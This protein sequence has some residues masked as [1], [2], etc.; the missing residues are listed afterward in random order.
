MEKQLNLSKRG[1][2]AYAFL[3]DASRP[4]KPSG[5]ERQRVVNAN[6]TLALELHKAVI[7][8][9]RNRNATRILEIGCGDGN[10]LN[11]LAKTNRFRDSYLFGIDQSQ[12]A[13]KEAKTKSKIA[14]LAGRVKFAVGRNDKIPYHGKF[15]LVF[16]VLSFHEWKNGYTSIPYILGRISE[17]GAFIIY[18]TMPIDTKGF[19]KYRKYGSR[20]F[21]KRTQETAKIVFHRNG[22]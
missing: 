7:E 22:G 4:R 2:K 14:G 9:L 19:L 3:T 12:K 15:D 10:M 5:K 21:I 11:K 6:K 13:I 16:S 1:V 8:D 17:G 20:L 18:D